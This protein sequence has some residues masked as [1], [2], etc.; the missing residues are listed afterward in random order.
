M[1]FHGDSIIIAEVNT[2]VKMVGSIVQLEPMGKIWK[3]PPT[4]ITLTYC[5]LQVL[6]AKN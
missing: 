3:H 4:S 6:V 2:E 1:C 5:D